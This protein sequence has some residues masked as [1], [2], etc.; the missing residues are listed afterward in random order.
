M[1]LCQ[2]I[3]AKYLYRQI[4][5]LELI[6]QEFYTKIMGFKVIEEEEKGWSYQPTV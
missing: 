4:K 3:I 5:G 2:N 1:I 6:G